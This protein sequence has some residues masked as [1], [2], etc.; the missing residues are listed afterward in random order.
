MTWR[1]SSGHVQL[2]KP[3][4]QRIKLAKMLELANDTIFSLDR[5]KSQHTC[6]CPKPR[7]AQDRIRQTKTEQLQ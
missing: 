7:T 2:H 6:A 3:A 1:I 5:T 4:K